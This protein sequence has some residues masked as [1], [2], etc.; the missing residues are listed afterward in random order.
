M[1]EQD[2]SGY[3]VRTRR[4]GNLTISNMALIVLRELGVPAHF[5]VI[6]DNINKRFPGRNLKANHV[7][8]YLMSP[9]FRWVDR[10]TY[11]LAEWGLPEIRPKENYA[12]AKE[13]IRKT[14]SIIGKPATIVDIN[15]YLNTQIDHDK[16]FIWLSRPNIILCNN[17]KLFVSVGQSKWALKEWNLPLATVKDTIPLA[18]DILAEEE[19]LWLTSQQLYIEMK[20]RGWAGTIIVLKR[21]LDRE[22]QKKDRRIRKEELH[23]FNIQMY[24]LSTSNWNRENTLEKLLVE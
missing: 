14:L 16:D 6:A 4:A 13:A 7:S 10:G 20:S 8:N 11:G 23:G 17:P 19:T 22:I 1:I 18:C 2:F 3:L 12:A 21:A 9:L 15:E 5:T 24:G